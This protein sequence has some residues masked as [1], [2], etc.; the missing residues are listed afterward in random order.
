MVHVKRKSDGMRMTLNEDP[1]VF[2]LA[3]IVAKS[4]WV[5]IYVNHKVVKLNDGLGIQPCG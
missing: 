4:K 1:L 3:V 5:T 2:E